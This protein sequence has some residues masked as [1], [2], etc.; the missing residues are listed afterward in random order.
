MTVRVAQ[1]SHKVL[2]RA[3]PGSLGWGGKLQ[4][5]QQLAAA[6]IVV[7]QQ[8]A[9]NRKDKG[10]GGIGVR[11]RRGRMLC[12]STSATGRQRASVRGGLHLMTPVQTARGC[13]RQPTTS[14][15]P[16]PVDSFYRRA[17]APRCGAGCPQ[18][19]V[20]AHPRV[21]NSRRFS[22]RP[23]QHRASRRLAC[24]DINTLSPACRERGRASD[25]T[26]RTVGN[27]SGC[28]AVVA[29]ALGGRPDATWRK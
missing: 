27:C 19:G 14:R 7:A 25:I 28:G 2:R 26:V 11:P 1:G 5:A 29:Q 20:T 9:I 18:H 3:Q 16:S 22:A 8:W 4:H 23:R 21:A 10:E 12:R 6:D 15:P 24:G 17:V 13:R